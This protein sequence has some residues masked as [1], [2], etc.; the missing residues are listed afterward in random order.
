MDC[1][2]KFMPKDFY[3]V[4]LKI[5]LKNKQGGVL[6]LK[7]VDNGS[8]A[9]YYDLPGGR[10]NTDEFRTT[11]PKIIEREIIEEIGKIKYKL[12]EKSAALGRHLI[13]GKYLRDKKDI[14][15]FYVFFE[16]GYI[17]GEIKVSPEHTGYKWVDLEKIKLADYFKSGILEGLKMYMGR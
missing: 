8:Y 5:I 2:N 7:A 11:L 6:L 15:C 9:G 12:N 3:Q 16:A 14:H 4:S 10:I 13:P 17:K 1:V